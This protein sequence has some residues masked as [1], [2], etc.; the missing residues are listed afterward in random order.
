M[1]LGTQIKH[2]SPILKIVGYILDDPQFK[3]KFAEKEK[4]ADFLLFEGKIVCEVKT[5]EAINVPARIEGLRN[6]DNQRNFEQKFFRTMRNNCSDANKQI[7]QTKE[8]L[9]L[10]GAFGLL[11]LENTIP[12]NY[13]SLSL[14]TATSKKM[15]SGWASVDAT[16]CIDLV[17]TIA[18]PSGNMMKHAAIVHREAVFTQKPLHLMLDQIMHD[19]AKVYGAP[20]L[21]G[22][23]IEKANQSWLTDQHGK[24][25]GYKATIDFIKPLPIIKK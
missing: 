12:D 16:L 20:V 22:Y 25:A 19:F 10:N 17:N 5:V 13:S 24:Y 11:I 1:L 3:T 4:R 8:K 7:E 9:A 15:C 21:G 14:I 6:L 2:L 18:D 23:D